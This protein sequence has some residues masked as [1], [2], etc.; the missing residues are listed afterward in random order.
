MGGMKDLLAENDKPEQ[1]SDFNGSVFPVLP[2]NEDPAC[3]MRPFELYRLPEPCMDKR[4]LPRIADKTVCRCKVNRI[5][6]IV[7]FIRLLKFYPRLL[8]AYSER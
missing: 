7:D 1:L 4:F 6:A 2:R 3:R 8:H 5:L